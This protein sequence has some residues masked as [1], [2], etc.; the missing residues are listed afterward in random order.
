MIKKILQGLLLLV[1]V[2]WIGATWYTSQTLEARLRTLIRDDPSNIVE[3]EFDPF[4]E[5]E[6]DPLLKDRVWLSLI[7]YRRS[8][9]ASIARL[10]LH[11]QVAPDGEPIDIPLL[12]KFH[13]G[14]LMFA[15]GPAIGAA[16]VQLTLD[17]D[18]ERRYIPPRWGREALPE[19][20]SALLRGVLAFDGAFRGRSWLQQVA[21]QGPQMQLEIERMRFAIASDATLSE[22][23]VDG[24]MATLFAQYANDTL[25]IEKADMALRANNA[26]SNDRYEGLLSVNW[27]DA[28]MDFR[29][30]ARDVASMSLDTEYRM[31]NQKIDAEVNLNAENIG[32]QAEKPEDREVLLDYGEA[33]A[34]VGELPV[35]RLLEIWD[36][37]R[38]W[39][40]P[41]AALKDAAD[42]H[43]EWRAAEVLMQQ[44]SSDVSAYASLKFGVDE[45]EF[46]MRANAE[47]IGDK[48]V[49]RLSQV[50]TVGQLFDYL[51][52][53]LTYQADGR[54]AKIPEVEQVLRIG[55]DMDMLEMDEYGPSGSVHVRAGEVRVNGRS[56]EP[57]QF[58][59]D[60]YSQRIWPASA[61]AKEPLSEHPQ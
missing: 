61:A 18:A 25:K 43:A 30:E 14:P 27:R 21:L 40:P 29:G 5:P 31:F 45:Q 15:G 51:L 3:V 10:Q 41:T 4:A 34:A 48:D 23:L 8:F 49:D 28:A 38:L 16:R 36:K 32:S 24:D 33:V 11:V 6:V 2:G 54:L 12:L 17:Y 60:I 26:F 46:L 44:V 37:S 20:G 52:A 19:E 58:L 47:F 22:I 53:D 42:E 13:H 39:E 7:S 35:E 50:E 59:Q 56:L 57:E 55:R 9:L 1:F